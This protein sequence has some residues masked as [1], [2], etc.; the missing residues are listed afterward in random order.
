MNDDFTDPYDS[1]SAYGP[2]SATGK[3]GASG[4]HARGERE[5]LARL[6]FASLEEQRAARRWRI[7]FRLIFLG[8]FLGVGFLLIPDDFEADTVPGGRHTALIDIYGEI[9]D[10]SDASADLVN[11]GLRAAFEHED[12]AAIILRINSPGGSPVQAGIIYDEILRLRAIYPDISVYAVI[13][14]IGASAAY[15]VAAAADI[16][17][18]NRASL[19]GSIGVK[20]EDFGFDEAMEEWG[21]ERRVF[22]SGDDKQFLDPFSPLEEKDALRAQIL[23]EQVH[24]QFVEAVEQGRGE[25]LR[26]RGIDIFSGAFWTGE[27]ALSLG[28][29]DGLRSVDD[30]AREIIG[31]EE[32]ADFTVYPTYDYIDIL[33]DLA[34]TLTRIGIVSEDPASA[35]SRPPT[36]R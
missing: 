13:V 28:L 31:V 25:R 5:L 36:I 21:I 20:I 19:V 15:Y 32:I 8:L 34:Q 10:W 14:D 27:E 29:I 26:P 3:G 16:I 1:A 12:T 7:A 2:S 9:A 6:A 33:D 17:H 24:R 23:I 18:A 11:D 30:V 35:F 22:T 4:D